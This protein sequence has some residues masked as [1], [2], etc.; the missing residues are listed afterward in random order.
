MGRLTADEREAITGAL[1]ALNSLV[2]I[3]EEG[4]QPGV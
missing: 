3:L 2:Q 1:P 4:I